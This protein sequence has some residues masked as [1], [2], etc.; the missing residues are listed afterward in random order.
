M[1]SFPP[2][3][4]RHSREG[5]NPESFPRCRAY[6]LDSR[7]SLSSGSPTARPVGGNDGLKFHCF[8]VAIANPSFMRGDDLDL[9]Q[10]TGCDE[11]RDLH[12][13]ARWLV[14]LLLGAEE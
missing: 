10:I 12:R 9:D 8:F 2:F 3:P 4:Y 13:G 7:R 1:G 6:W 14:R 11:C 5:G